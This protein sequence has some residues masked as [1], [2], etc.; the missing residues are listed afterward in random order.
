MLAASFVH[1]AVATDQRVPIQLQSRRLPCRQGQ[2]CWLRFAATLSG[3]LQASQR[4]A[5]V[6]FETGPESA[7]HDRQYRRLHPRRFSFSHD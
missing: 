3:P 7:D 4:P 2:K 5:L 6:A 1:R